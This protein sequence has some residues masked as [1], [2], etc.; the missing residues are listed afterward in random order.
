MLAIF[1]GVCFAAT[2]FVRHQ[3][4]TQN[5]FECTQLASETR[6]GGGAVTRKPG[7]AWLEGTPANGPWDKW[8]THTHEVK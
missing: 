6:T 5:G 3:E 8:Q 1:F 4:R 2:Q 7:S